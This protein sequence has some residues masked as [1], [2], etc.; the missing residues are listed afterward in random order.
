MT[1]QDPLV[2]MYRLKFVL[3]MLCFAFIFILL[4]L[5]YTDSYL[6]LTKLSPKLGEQCKMKW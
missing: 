2:K 5:Q 4:V 1:E 3:Q 6:S